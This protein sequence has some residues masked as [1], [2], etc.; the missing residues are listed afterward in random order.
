MHRQ[1]CARAHLHTNLQYT[2]CMCAACLPALP[3]PCTANA[4]NLFDYFA[5]ALDATLWGIMR[6]AM[7][8]EDVALLQDPDTRAT[9]FIPSATVRWRMAARP[10]SH[11]EAHTGPSI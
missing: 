7:T 10:H 2:R 3:P 1:Y 8:A 11:R 9:A 4:T 5:A 6:N